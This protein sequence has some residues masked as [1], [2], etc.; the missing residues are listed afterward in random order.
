MSRL[1]LTLIIGAL[2]AGIL[3]GFYCA[4]KPVTRDHETQVT[5]TVTKIRRVE[6]PGQTVTETI[7]VGEGRSTREQTK[8]AAKWH[9][10]AGVATR[11][12]REPPVY[13]AAVERRVL[14]PF[15]VG[16]YAQTS[17]AVGVRLGMEF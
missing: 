2:C 5:R 1:N 16:A 3:V 12:D 13:E 11:F 15:F 14:G 4:P 8:A 10:S 7:I 9:V 6:V 17:G